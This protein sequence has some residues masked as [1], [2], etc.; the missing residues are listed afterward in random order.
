MNFFDALNDFI[1]I[2]FI[3][4]LSFKFNIALEEIFSFFIY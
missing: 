3:R 2:E 1:F 4:S